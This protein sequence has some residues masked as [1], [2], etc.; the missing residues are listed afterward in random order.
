[1][2]S[3]SYW[4][5]RRSTD[6]VR[7]DLWGLGVPTSTSVAEVMQVNDQRGLAKIIFEM[8]RLRLEHLRR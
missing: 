8:F 3:I 4:N 6:P 2:S 1:M 7:Q 5:A